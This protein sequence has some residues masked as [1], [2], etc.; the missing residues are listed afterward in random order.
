MNGFLKMKKR[1]RKEN[2]WLFWTP[3][4]LAIVFTVFISLFALDVFAEGYTFWQAIGAFLIHLVPTYILIIAIVIA[5]RF[6]LAGGIIFITLGIW[7]IIMTF[8]DIHYLTILII[9][10]PLFIIGILFLVNYFLIKKKIR[11]S[12]KVK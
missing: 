3:R 5:W 6:E 10:V 12:Q 9:P 4:I 1:K 8:R 11:K 2:K 7:Y